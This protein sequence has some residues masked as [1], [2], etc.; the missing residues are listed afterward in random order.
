MLLT[1]KPVVSASDWL[2]LLA[3]AATL[4]LAGES[5]AQ[6]AQPAPQQTPASPTGT[7][8]SHSANPPS[9]PPQRRTQ[10]AYHGQTIDDRVKALAKALDLNQM[11]QAGLKAVLEH[12][13]S[14]VRLIQFDE[15]LSG[16]ERIGKFRALQE[17]TVLR[18]RALLNDEQKKK[19]EP[20]NHQV[21]KENSSDYVDQWMR[22]HQ[23]T[24]QP[25]QAP[26]K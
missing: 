18:I 19:Y 20:L 23:R 10:R 4:T 8:S 7:E 11:Q 16:E 26:K 2:V 15:T 24:E 17:D 25:P 12:Q 14:Q 13:Q 5:A 3:L 22:Y 6:T 21:E 1:N 9:V